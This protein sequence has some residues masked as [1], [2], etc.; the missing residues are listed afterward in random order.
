MRLIDKDPELYVP[1]ISERDND[2][3]LIASVQNSGN[4][5]IHFVIQE[6]TGLF[7]VMGDLI[8]GDPSQNPKPV[9]WTDSY[10][11][12]HTNIMNLMIAQYHAYDDWNTKFVVLESLPEVTRF[13]EEFGIRGDLRRF[14]IDLWNSKQ[15]GNQ[16]L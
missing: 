16:N 4:M 6:N 1:D 14:A 13:L 11:R 5:F 10:N 9:K 12:G 15:K 7:F 3:F 2:C 8:T